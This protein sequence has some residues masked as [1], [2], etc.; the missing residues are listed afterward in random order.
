MELDG[1]NS[2][3]FVLQVSEEDGEVASVMD[4]A[5]SVYNLYQCNNYVVQ[6]LNK[7]I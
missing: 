3:I 1:S 5:L 6:C 2:A 7:L 4:P